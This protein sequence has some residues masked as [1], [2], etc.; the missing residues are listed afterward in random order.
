MSQLT[1]IRFYLQFWITIADD[2]QSD[3][4]PGITLMTKETYPFDPVG[5]D[6]LSSEIFLDKVYENVDKGSFV[7]IFKG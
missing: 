2:I 7:M 3:F 5:E 4:R 6:I 1:I